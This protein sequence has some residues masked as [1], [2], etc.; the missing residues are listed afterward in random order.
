MELV[1][2]WPHQSSRRGRVV[3]QTG[4]VPT[5]RQVCPGEQEAGGQGEGGEQE[6]RGEPP[7]PGGHLHTGCRRRMEQEELE[8]QMPGQ[9]PP[10]GGGS[11]L[12]VSGLWLGGLGVSGL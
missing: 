10:D 4:V 12:G 7:V 8:E 1:R 9:R 2:C 11:G 3:P 5:R 6:A